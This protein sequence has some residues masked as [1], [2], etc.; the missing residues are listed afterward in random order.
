MNQSSLFGASFNNAK[1]SPS[2]PKTIKDTTSSFVP[3]SLKD[4]FLIEDD[5]ILILRK[6]SY[7]A[8]KRYQYPLLKKCID[9]E[10][11]FKKGY[12]H[13]ALISKMALL[14]FLVVPS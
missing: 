3:L 4:G 14:D 5:T 11:A 1:E 12:Y 13:P 8:M 10:I 6:I 2:A 9:L 7:Q